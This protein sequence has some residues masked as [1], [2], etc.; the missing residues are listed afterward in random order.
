V[1]IDRNFSPDFW[2]HIM[3][4][5]IL[6]FLDALERFPLVIACVFDALISAGCCRKNN[7]ID[8]QVADQFKSGRLYAAIASR[9]GQCG[10]C[11]GEPFLPSER[12]L[13]RDLALALSEQG[14]A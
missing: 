1:Y 9:P 13:A 5:M 8:P 2:V 10:R 12:D 7:T 4:T 3:C 11:D 6:R 14:T